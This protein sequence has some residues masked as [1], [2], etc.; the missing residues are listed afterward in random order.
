MSK[1]PAAATPAK[2]DAKG[3]KDALSG[4]TGK[5]Y[6]SLVQIMTKDPRYRVF[7]PCFKTHRKKNGF[8]L[9]QNFFVSLYE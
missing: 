7:P 5:K 8:F 6:K 4:D 1:T 9:T 3:G 2:A